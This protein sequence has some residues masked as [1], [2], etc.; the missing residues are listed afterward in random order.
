MKPDHTHPIFSADSRRVAIQ[1][2]S[3]T[4]GK[5]LDIMVVDVP[6]ALLK[7]YSSDK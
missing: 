1:S 7:R 5:S 3:L 2:G 4:D 6:S